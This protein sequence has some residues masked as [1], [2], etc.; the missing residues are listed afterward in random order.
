[1]VVTMSHEL[2]NTGLTQ[3][4]ITLPEVT[5]TADP[6]STTDESGNVTLSETKVYPSKA[7]STPTP[8][9]KISS[10]DADALAKRSQDR[11][12]LINKDQKTA[13]KNAGILLVD[14]WIAPNATAPTDAT[15]ARN[16]A[17]AIIGNDLATAAVAANFYFTRQRWLKGIVNG[18]EEITI[19]DNKD[20]AKKPE[21]DTKL[22]SEE[23]TL[24][25]EP[26]FCYNNTTGNWELHKP[27]N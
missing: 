23:K 20:E 18:T 14:T 11:Y 10:L 22:E 27:H 6:T 19:L 12:D 24:P 7:K 9:S 4:K 5:I 15:K 1:M 2:K 17:A 26:H 13:L 21:S 3:P 16:D 25:K 8:A